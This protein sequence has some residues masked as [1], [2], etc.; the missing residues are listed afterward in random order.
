LLHSSVYSQPWSWSR[1]SF[2]ERRPSIAMD[3]YRA[4]NNS[5][6]VEAW[7]KF[8]ASKDELHNHNGPWLYDLVDITRQILSN[9]F[10]DVHGLFVASYKR[11]DIDNNQLLGNALLEIITLLDHILGSNPNYLLGNWIEDAKKW[12]KNSQ[13]MALYEFN[14]RN[15]ITLWGPT[16]QISDYA[17]KSWAG[18]YSTYYFQRWSFFINKVRAALLAKQ[19]F[20]QNSYDH[21]ILIIEQ[22][23]DKQTSTFPTQPTNNTLQLALSVLEKYGSSTSNYVVKQNTD[24]NGHDIYQAWTVDL[25]QLKILCDLDTTCRGFNSNGYL[26][27]QVN[28]TEVVAGCNLYIKQ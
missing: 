23:W 28:V 18:L 12:A 21:D 4:A 6:L 10:V 11:S 5:M 27:T 13:E 25:Q 7:R 22:N 15:Q 20:D 14:A 16:G 9:F 3:M 8:L 26:K 2:M 19:P 17:S 1:K 24:A